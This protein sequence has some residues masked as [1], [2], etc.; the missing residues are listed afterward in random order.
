MPYL[1]AYAVLLPLLV[2]ALLL[3][4]GERLRFVTGGLAVGAVA[5]SL[6]LALTV[7][8]QHWNAA[9]A[10]T[11]WAWFNVGGQ[12]FTVGLWLDNLSVAL[13][14]LVPLVAFPVFVFAAKYMRHE[15]RY[16]AFFGQLLLFVAAMLA[17]VLARD[18]LAAVVAWELVGFA[19]WLL[20]GF[21]F[22]KPEAA[23]AARQAFLLNRLG[24]LGLFVAIGALRAAAGTLDLPALTAAAPQLLTS[25][26][27]LL[28]LAGAGLLLAAVAKSGQWPL[29]P[30]LPDAMAG[31]TPVSALLHAATLVAAGAYLLLRTYPLLPA[32][33][34]AAAAIIG[35][36]TALWAALAAQ[37]ETDLKRVL[38][39]STASQLGYVFLGVGIGAPVAAALHLL[40]HAAFKAS[41]FL[42]AGLVT[43]AVG[44]AAAPDK[45][46][47][48]QD[49][50]LLGGLRHALPRTFA[51]YVLAAAALVGLPLTT[52]FLTKEALLAGTLVWAG[53]AGGGGI[54][55][56]VPLA[57]LG[58]V[59]LTARYMARHGKLIFGGSEARGVF[60]ISQVHE[61][62]SRAEAPLA[63]LLPVTGLAALALWLTL[64]PNPL[65]VAPGWAAR[66]LLMP[67]PGGLPEVGGLAVWLPLLSVA[68]VG[69]GV[70]WGLQAPVPATIARPARISLAVFWHQRAP[71]AALG[72][73]RIVA[74]FDHV[75]LDRQ[76]LRFGKTVV[77]VAKLTAWT[78]RRVVDGAVHRLAAAL[79]GL[80]RLAR[81][82]QSG[83]TQGYYRWAV[84][85]LLGAVAW[86]ATR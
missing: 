16:A 86:V 8:A 38:A 85:A 67:F 69:G 48:P 72:L 45:M 7:F 29:T 39:Y 24:D 47:D 62:G 41:L 35:A 19:S 28:A 61:A 4:T 32:E 82:A 9:P 64:A 84:A 36:S 3:L 5:G 59:G 50:R 77:V 25:Q 53:G 14:A 57:A 22:T 74:R 78:D 73:A 55:W 27:A 20:I 6:A 18:L 51:A 1:A 80:G 12:P 43:H 33:V 17:L 30:W 13:L 76:V 37:R 15:A 10:G 2:G 65:H 31:P 26:P 52:G 60:R 81:A 34:R 11:T 68:L 56:L 71:A 66:G 46:V 63:L 54:A 75:G 70:W 58:T 42:N 21:W 23:T 44:H 83:Q 79:G 49:M 40:A